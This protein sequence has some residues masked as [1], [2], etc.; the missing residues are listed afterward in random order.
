MGNTVIA[1][2]VD[3]ECIIS[4][5]LMDADGFTI[6]RTSNQFK[7]TAMNEILDLNPD[8]DLIT[9]VGENSTV[10]VSRSETG[11]CIIIQC[12]NDGNLGKARLKLTKAKVAILPFL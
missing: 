1:D 12:P 10:I 5:A 8:S 6:E 4:A 11:H 9:L 3:N 7:P 2:L